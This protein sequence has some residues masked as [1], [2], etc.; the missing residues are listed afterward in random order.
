MLLVLDHRDST[1]RYQNGTLKLTR[2]GKSAQ[3]IP[4]NQL[5]HLV[6]YGN[7]T[8]ETR[9]WRALAQ[10]AIPAT[11]LS[12]RGQEAV[13]YLGQGLSTQLPLRRM[14]H[15]LAS[16][17]PA[18]LEISRYLVAQK[19]NSYDLPLNTLK[20]QYETNDLL[21]GFSS[22]I[23]AAKIQLT[24]SE[25]YPTLL[26]IE[27][28]VAQGWFSLLA[29]ILPKRWTF[30]HR[31]RQPP[32]DPINALLSLGYTLAASDLRQVVC[33]NGLDPSLGFLHQDY[34]GRD[35][36]VLDILETFRAAVDDFVLNWV[37]EN[38]NPESC[39]YYREADGC[40]LSK[41]ARPLFY[42]AWANQREYWPRPFFH[43]PDRATNDST[44]EWPRAPL[45]E[46]ANGQI[47]KLREEFKIIADNN[48]K[49]G[50]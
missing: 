46:V 9:V 30:T 44:D 29:A 11:L 34:P 5:E 1:L 42:E 10:A 3:S 45:F 41:Q 14:Q 15:Q 38:P 35:S 24:Q 32:R 28:Q 43:L 8:I 26:G 40:R 33:A 4:I 13:A 49:N 47:N 16:L 37:N 31:N 22:R 21:V 17:S 18:K 36:M 12:N 39:F 48:R 27:G 7:P 19:L 50:I 2:H 20:T 25:D 23:E 6:V